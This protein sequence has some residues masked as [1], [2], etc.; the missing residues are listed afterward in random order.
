[1]RSLPI[2]W[3][4]PL[5]RVEDRRAWTIELSRTTHPGPDACCAA[6]VGSACAAWAIEGAE[7]TLLLEVARAEAAAVAEPCGADERINDMLAAVAAGQWQPKPDCLGPDSYETLTRVLW[8]MINEPHLPEALLAAVRL[9]G[10]TDTVA[11]LVGGLLS[12]RQTPAEVRA[13]LPWSGDVQ[14]PDD[15]VIGPLAAGI[16]DLRTERAGG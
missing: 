12:C 5:D 1:M 11:A 9:G 10:D 4:L 15:A 8:C 14:A 3:A 6:L 7:P 13:Q 16:A 2:G